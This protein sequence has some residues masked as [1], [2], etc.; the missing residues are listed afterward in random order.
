MATPSSD[1]MVLCLVV[2]LEDFVVEALAFDEVA[3]KAATEV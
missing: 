1:E 2:W 3:L